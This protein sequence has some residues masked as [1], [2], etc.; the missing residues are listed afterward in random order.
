MVAN[1][2]VMVVKPVIDSEAISVSS[3]DRALMYSPASVEDWHRAHNVNGLG[4]F[5]CYKHAAIKMRQ[6]NNKSGR[7]IGASSVAGKMGR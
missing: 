6:L 2:G 1:A 5:L 7:I 3:P 4:T